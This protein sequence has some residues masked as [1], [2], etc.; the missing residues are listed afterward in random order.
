MT[1]KTTID[2][3][4]IERTAPATTEGMG[5]MTLG[6]IKITFKIQKSAR[7]RCHQIIQKQKWDPR[8][9]PPGMSQHMQL[10][11]AASQPAGCRRERWRSGPRC[12]GGR[13]SLDAMPHLSYAHPVP[14]VISIG[15]C[16]DGHPAWRE[17]SGWP[18]NKDSLKLP[19]AHSLP[20]ENYKSGEP[21]GH[22]LPRGPELQLGYKCQPQ[23]RAQ[24][25]LPYF[26]SSPCSVHT[27]Q[28]HP[29]AN[30]PTWW[31][32]ETAVYML[33]CKKNKRD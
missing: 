19:P 21:L 24:T 16:S 18:Q 28:G 14:P 17:Q 23:V 5:S 33:V 20:C 12:S 10:C 4:D 27:T 3:C 1:F 7:Q 30:S 13:N 29:A 11:S 26:H 32:A 31:A 2:S 25:P 22:V 15:V 6:L 9:Y 8:T